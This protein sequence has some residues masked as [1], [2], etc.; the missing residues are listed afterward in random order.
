MMLWGA[1]CSVSAICRHF[2]FGVAL[3]MYV[4]LAEMDLQFRR[5]ADGAVSH[6]KCEMGIWECFVFWNKGQSM[7]KLPC[8]KQYEILDILIVISLAILS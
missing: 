1:G 2:S 8:L 7:P 6:S 5:E 3:E 4:K